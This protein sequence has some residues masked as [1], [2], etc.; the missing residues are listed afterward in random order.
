[1]AK[2][3]LIKNLPN[4]FGLIFIRKAKIF[5]LYF[6][7]LLLPLLFIILIITLPRENIF[8]VH[9]ETD[10]LQLK[11]SSSPLNEWNISG[12]TLIEDPFDDVKVILDDDD[13]YILLNEKTQVSLLRNSDSIFI[14]LSNNGSIGKINT[15][16]N[17]KTLGSYAE[18]ILPINDD[19]LSI[20]PFEG[21]AIL[22]EDISSGVRHILK[23]AE[24]SVIEERLF[25][26]AR[27]EAGNYTVGSGGRLS[28]YIDD[29]K[30]QQA[31]IKGFIEI[32][33]DGLFYTSHGKATL[34]AVNRLGSTGYDLK[35]DFWARIV[36]DPVIIALTTLLA[37]IFLALE[38]LIMIRQVLTG[39]E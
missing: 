7:L 18:I 37:T 4:Q 15:A 6:T 3:K 1:M 17:D 26:A 10:T 13:T 30:Q 12:G 28:F 27:Y 39:E 23:S 33:S 16:S 24:I 8:S 5:N 34:A 38:F 22:G 25:Q 35:P 32:N 29:N 36:S 14:G 21:S 11:L 19:T 20:F 2:F 9:A 31:I